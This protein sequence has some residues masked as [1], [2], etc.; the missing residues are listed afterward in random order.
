MQLLCRTRRKLFQLCRLHFKTTFTSASIA[1]LWY[2]E[3]VC[4]YAYLEA[5]IPVTV[6]SLAKV[7]KRLGLALTIW[8]TRVFCQTVSHPSPPL[9]IKIYKGTGY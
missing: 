1:D 4:V 5:E 6:D 9:M 3:G 2:A 7:Y 8:K